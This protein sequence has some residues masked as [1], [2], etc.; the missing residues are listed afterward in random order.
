MLAPV[1]AALDA[2]A[3]LSRVVATTIHPVSRAGRLGIESLSQETIALLSQSEPPVSQV[4]PRGVAFDCA[5][6]S[7]HELAGEAE[8]PEER[9]AAELRRL[10]GTDLRLALSA[11]QVPTFVGDGGSLSVET[12]RPLA[13]EEAVA[14]LEKAPG[15]ELWIGDA[16]PC[17]RD[18]AGREDVLVGRPRR[19]LSV[20]NGLQLW[21]AAD[22][23][24]VVASNVAKL[25]EARRPLA[26]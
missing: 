3:G 23:L 11:V 12:A 8:A 24:G 25:L 17:T 5:Q 1:L 20:E 13:I 26:S 21:I 6:A 4:F 18:T 22:G 14:A 9:A 10:L 19:D 15:V 2:A 16:Q 7:S